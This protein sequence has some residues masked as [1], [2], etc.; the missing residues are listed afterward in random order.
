MATAVVAT[1]N[2]NLEPKIE[3]IATTTVTIV[4]QQ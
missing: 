4:T 1:P 2:K 3:I